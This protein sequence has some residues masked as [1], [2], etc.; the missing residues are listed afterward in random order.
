MAHVIFDLDGTVICSKHRAN[1]LPDGSLDLANWFENNT[2]EKIMRDSLLPLARIMRQ[3]YNTGHSIIICT[4]RSPHDSIHHFLKENDLPH[5]VY[6]SRWTGCIMGDAELKVKLL[7]DYFVKELGYTSVGAAK[8]LMFDDN[9]KV[10]DAMIGLG[11]TVVD[12]NV[13]NENL[14]KLA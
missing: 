3:M 6:L 14:R 10:I 7:N 12:A 2:H 13:A 8:A 5:H 4:A 11:I 1:I 9:L